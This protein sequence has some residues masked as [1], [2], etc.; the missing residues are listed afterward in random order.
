[1]NLLPKCDLFWV[2]NILVHNHVLRWTNWYWRHEF[3]YF[4]QKWPQPKTFGSR[5]SE[6]EVLSVTFYFIIKRL[7]FSIT[8]GPGT[9]FHNTLILNPCTTSC[10]VRLIWTVST[11][12][13]LEDRLHFHLIAYTILILHSIWL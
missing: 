3:I 2:L 13:A 4:I 10:P 8:T 5:L 1:M 6:H 9:C 11:S 7:R 12:V